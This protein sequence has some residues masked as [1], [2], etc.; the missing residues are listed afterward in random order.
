[1][2]PSSVVMRVS[3]SMKLS[4]TFPKRLVS[5]GLSA[6][7]SP[8]VIAVYA[9]WASLPD[10][11]PGVTS[12][13]EHVV[14]GLACIGVFLLCGRSAVP[15]R[16]PGRRYE[17][18]PPVHLRLYGLD[19]HPAARHVRPDGGEHD[20]LRYPAALPFFKGLVSCQV[21]KVSRL[22]ELGVVSG[23]I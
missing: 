1:M 10:I 17:A 9:I 2:Y 22:D 14:G 15:V 11:K 19:L 23:V 13:P 4:L 21:L 18:V 7:T 5:R 16:L 6:S 20:P 3:W 8:G 12:R